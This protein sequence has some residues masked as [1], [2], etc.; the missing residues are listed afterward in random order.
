VLVHGRQGKGK[1]EGK[2]TGK[3]KGKGKGNG[4]KIVSWG[5]KATSGF[6]GKG[7]GAVG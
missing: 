2:F 4:R 3:S 7:D 5:G 6:R 1:G